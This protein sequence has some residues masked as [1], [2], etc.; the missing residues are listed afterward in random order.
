MK[1]TR[2]N[3]IIDHKSESPLPP[4][5]NLCHRI[6][7]AQK[8]WLYISA[9]FDDHLYAIEGASNVESAGDRGCISLHHLA[10]AKSKACTCCPSPTACFR[11]ISKMLV[12]IVVNGHAPF[13][14]FQT[15]H[16]EHN[17]YLT[18]H[19]SHPRPLSTWRARRSSGS[20]SEI[21]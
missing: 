9:S 1:Q 3:H 16:K 18:K 7:G 11:I 4:F 15:Q 2:F 17:F 19:F 14:E 20:S 6:S 21:P 8:A 12:L 13:K 5:K 10:L